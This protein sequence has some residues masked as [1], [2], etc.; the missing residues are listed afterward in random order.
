LAAPLFLIASP[1]LLVVVQRSQPAL[2]LGPYRAHRRDLFPDVRLDAQPEVRRLD[3]FQLGGNVRQ[4]LAL[5]AN[6]R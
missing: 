4:A 6:L 5:S 1:D 3:L 2:D